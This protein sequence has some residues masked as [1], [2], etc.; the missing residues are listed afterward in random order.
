[1]KHLRYALIAFGLL[2]ASQA[3]A[4]TCFW[5]G[6]TGTWSTS[7]GV[8]WASSTGGTAS[9]CAATGGVPK[10]SGD[11]ATFDGNSGASAV[12][13]VDS[14][15]NGVS[16]GNIITDACVCTLD[17]SV[18]NPSMTLAGFSSN[19]S[20]VR[21][22]KMGSGT[23]HMQGNNVSWGFGTTTN[24]TFTPGTFT[25]AFDGG[26]GNKSWNTGGKTYPNV[27]FS[28]TITTFAPVVTSS[29]S[30]T[31][32]NLTMAANVRWEITAPNTMTIT[33]AYTLAGSSATSPIIIEN[34]SN[35][36]G[37]A[38]ISIASGTATCNW[39][40]IQGITFSGGATFTA[41]NSFGYN[42]TGITVTGPS[43][44]GGGHIIG[45]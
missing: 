41:T 9:T 36:T 32:T 40:I 6:G 28:T 24:L 3:E 42:T 30:A 15:I 43:G 21:T 23:F 29:G 38:T 10:Q 31:I 16:I 18:N 7:N 17:F 5:V 35:A 27:S 4:A 20:S 11:I 25:L 14:T 8:N 19:G 39:C 33:N 37:V 13:T 12:I 45:G 34:S 2:F 26:G 1:M 44:G 22:L